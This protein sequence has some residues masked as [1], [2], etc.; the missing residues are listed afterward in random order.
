MNE[1][2]GHRVSRRAVLRSA[3]LVGA[4]AGAGSATGRANGARTRPDFPEYVRDAR[5]GTYADLRGESSV[6]IAV[7][8][9]GRNFAFAPALTWVDRGT[10]VTFEWVS[11]HHNVVRWTRP[12]GTDW[13]GAGSSTYD[14]G[15]THS[16]T[17]ETPGMYTYYCQPHDQLGMKGAIAVGPDVPTTER[18]LGG[19]GDTLFGVPLPETPVQWGVATVAVGGAT[20]FGTAGAWLWWNS[21]AVD[22][23]AIDDLAEDDADEAGGA[24]ATGSGP[25]RFD[26]HLRQA[27]EHRERA[28]AAF[29]D[30]EYERA[31][32]ALDRA[33]AELDRAAEL[34]AE[35]GLDAGERV[36]AEREVVASLRKRCER[37]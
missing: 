10:T 1:D 13:Q 23:D 15:H 6:T 27:V 28:E 17:F 11:D 5:G 18:A 2:E 30:D 21:A 33:A 34:D 36:A 20:I 25:E 19:E 26:R 7:G 37:R 31:R 22:V 8:A 12:D 24:L 16:H 29:T 3:A 35:R 32:E 14:T 4:G 9:G